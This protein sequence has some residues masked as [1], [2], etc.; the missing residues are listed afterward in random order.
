MTI[1]CLKIFMK[2]FY[3]SLNILRSFEI[4]EIYLVSSEIILVSKCIKVNFMRMYYVSNGPKNVV[5]IMPILGLQNGSLL[6]LISGLDTV[7]M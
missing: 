5:K 6:I 4:L 3:S 1:D 2:Y 7:W